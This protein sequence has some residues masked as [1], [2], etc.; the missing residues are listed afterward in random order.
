MSDGE[1]TQGW[2]PE[3]ASEKDLRRELERAF[4]YRGDIF[5]TR[6]D[7]TTVEGYIYDRQA[8]TTLADSYIRMIQIAG[9]E[10]LQVSYADVARLAFTGKDS[11]AG[12]SWEAWVRK[13]QKKKAAGEKNIGLASEALD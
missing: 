13:Y 2:V 12:K 10:K 5:I 6:K 1:I 3:L 11:A 8:G 7:G 9:N 4:D